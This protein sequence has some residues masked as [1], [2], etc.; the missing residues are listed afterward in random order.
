M[1]FNGPKIKLSD[2]DLPRIAHGIGCGEDEIHAFLE[3]ETSGSGYD[4]QGRPKMLFEPH[5][6]YRELGAGA[7]R[8]KAVAAGLAYAKWGTKPYPKDSYPR[9]IAAME[10]DPVA[11][12]RSASWGL[13]QV[14]GFNYAA[15][16]YDSVTE[17]VEAFVRLGEPEQL[18]A[19]VNFIRTNKLDDELRTHNWP[20]FA[21]GYN[22]AGYA[23]NKYDTKLAAAYLKWS[24]IKDTPW[25]PETLRDALNTAVSDLAL[26]PTTR[27]EPIQPALPEPDPIVTAPNVVKEPGNPL[28]LPPLAVQPT[29]TSWFGNL[30]AS[31]FSKPWN[32]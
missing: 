14:M 25:S 12:L 16:D 11:A 21:R 29:K 6:F 13:G 8:D 24:K 9:L 20:A 3:V 19:A 22:G 1:D 30:L 32:G 7:K 23:A 17:M 5:V 15:C 18:Q 26:P 31:I 10:I 4:S 28:G 27:V 2:T